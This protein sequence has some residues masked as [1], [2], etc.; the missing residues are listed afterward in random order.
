MSKAQPSAL[1]SALKRLKQRA[2]ASA[3]SVTEANPTPSSEQGKCTPS[4]SAGAIGTPPADGAILSPR[5]LSRTPVPK[6]AF[7]PKGGHRAADADVVQDDL[8]AQSAFT[9]TGDGLE[10]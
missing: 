9:V 5:A 7:T 6:A 2:A 1:S 3:A 10:A 8:R 4:T